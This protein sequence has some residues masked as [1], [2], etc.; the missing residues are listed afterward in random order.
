MP[1]DVL[2]NW[3]AGL[4][5]GLRA[6]EQRNQYRNLAEIHGV[7]FCSNDYLGLAGHPALHEAVSRAVHEAK[8]SVGTGSRL[9]CWPNRSEWHELETRFAAF[10]G[11]EAALYFTSGYAA[12]IGSAF[13]RWLLKTM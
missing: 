8:R 7:N 12:N 6:L 13:L 3:K 11:T 5:K 4:K 9:A 10:A 1:S 2:L